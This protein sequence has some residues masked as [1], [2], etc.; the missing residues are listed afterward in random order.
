LEFRL[1]EAGAIPMVVTN[2]PQ[3]IMWMEGI[4][5]IYG[6]TSNPYDSRKT[7]GGSSSGEGALLGAGGISFGIGKSFFTNNLNIF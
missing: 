2:V 4:N 1:R 6:R 5:S 3:A 7:C